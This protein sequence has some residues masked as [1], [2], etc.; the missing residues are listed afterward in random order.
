MYT[1]R[2]WNAALIE[3]SRL[4]IMACEYITASVISPSFL[5]GVVAFLANAHNKGGRAGAG[6]GHEGVELAQEKRVL[7]MSL[8]WRRD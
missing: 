4:G 7:D 1:I 2:I 6:W 5:G 3:Q 8:V